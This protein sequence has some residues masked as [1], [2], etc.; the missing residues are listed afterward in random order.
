MDDNTTSWNLTNNTNGT[1]PGSSGWFPLRQM[2]TE[3]IV[4]VVFYCILAAM[5]VFGNSLVIGAFY[6]NRRL[7]TTTNLL[8]LSLAIA[9]MVVGLITVPLWVYILMCYNAVRS[10]LK[11]YHMLMSSLWCPLFYISQLLLW[12]D[13]YALV[14]PIKTSQHQKNVW[15]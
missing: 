7:R 3:E 1:R 11:F 15:S 12:R 5:I 6:V 10:V 14:W 2:T 13:V 4:C 9:D 8:L